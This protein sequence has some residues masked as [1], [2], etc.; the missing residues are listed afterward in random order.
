MDKEFLRE[1]IWKNLPL[2]TYILEELSQ[3]VLIHRDFADH[4]LG[5]SIKLSVDGFERTLF[6]CNSCRPYLHGGSSLFNRDVPE[7]KNRCYFVMASRC[8]KV[9]IV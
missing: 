3:C 7:L 4:P 6:I 2:G 9:F 5:Y 8:K 1:V